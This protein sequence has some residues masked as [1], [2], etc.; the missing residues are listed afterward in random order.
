VEGLCTTCRLQILF[1]R[2]GRKSIASPGSCAASHRVSLASSCRVTRINRRDERVAPERTHVNALRFSETINGRPYVIEVVC[3]GRDR[4][5]A[6]IARIPGAMT[7]LM[8]FYG[9]T[10]DEAAG[11]LTHWLSRLG[12]GTASK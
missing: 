8:P 9:T 6:Q 1:A 12:R 10:P 7:A 2:D 3:I 5:R 4:W 11:G